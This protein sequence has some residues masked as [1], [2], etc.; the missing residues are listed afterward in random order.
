MV[1][2]IAVLCD[3][4]VC[5]LATVRLVVCLVGFW[6]SPVRW[7]R[8]LTSNPVLMFVTLFVNENMV[9]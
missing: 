6:Y 8:L 4:V 7:A 9:A 5:C 2:W 3:T 1:R